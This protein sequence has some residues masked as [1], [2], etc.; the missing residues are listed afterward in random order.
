VASWVA[1]DEL[2]ILDY[3]RWSRYEYVLGKRGLED[4][5]VYCKQIQE[6]ASKAPQLSL[7][8]H[9]FSFIIKREDRAATVESSL[10]LVFR[11][12]DILTQIRLHAFAAPSARLVDTNK[13]LHPVKQ[14]QRQNA[15]TKK[16]AMPESATAAKRHASKPAIK[17]AD[18][19]VVIK[20]DDKGEVQERSLKD[21]QTLES[22]DDI[23]RYICIVFHNPIHLHVIIVLYQRL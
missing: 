1:G 6:L 21:Q 5:L 11:Y 8:E 2:L 3:C 14:E 4:V 17:L 22:L 18:S 9:Y 16:V 13:H 20:T 15:D 19:E 7:L 10:R 23:C 12:A